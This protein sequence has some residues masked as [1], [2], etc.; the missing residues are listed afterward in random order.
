MLYFLDGDICFEHIEGAHHVESL[1]NGW[2]YDSGKFSL[3]QDSLET[4]PSEHAQSPIVLRLQ[5]H[6]G[7]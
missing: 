1:D 3:P 6:F 2:L 5:S 4:L 7:S